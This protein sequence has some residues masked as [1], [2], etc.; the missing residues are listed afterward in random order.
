MNLNDLKKIDFKNP[1][2]MPWPVKLLLLLVKL[3]DTTLT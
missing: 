3:K 1:G 2:G